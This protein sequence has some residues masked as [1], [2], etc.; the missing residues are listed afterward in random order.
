MALRERR[1]DLGQPLRTGLGVELVA[2]LGE[3]GRGIHVVVGP[4]RDDEHV[5]LVHARVRG[6]PLRLGVD[7]GDR[8][9]EHAHAGLGDVAVLEADRFRRLAP[10]HH[11]ELREAE[12]ERVG[13]VDQRHLDLVGDRLG[14]HGAQLQAAEPRSKDDHALAHPATLSL[15]HGAVLDSPLILARVF[16]RH[17]AADRDVSPEGHVADDRQALAGAQ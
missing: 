2:A 9:L 11:V 13:L 3:A 12:D 6:H 16:D 17:R 14:E 15:E 8:L 4:Q 7:R 1:Q 5:G 10:E